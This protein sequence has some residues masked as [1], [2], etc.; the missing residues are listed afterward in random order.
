MFPWMLTPLA[1][2]V[3]KGSETG[4]GLLMFFDSSTVSV[5]APPIKLKLAWILR[6]V[7]PSH[8]LPLP[9]R[10]DSGRKLQG[11]SQSTIVR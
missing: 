6:G 11:S 1:D 10:I 2:G 7:S 3:H 5:V 8:P 4:P 9:H